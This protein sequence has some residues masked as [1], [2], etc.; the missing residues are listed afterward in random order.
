ME[1]EA[2]LFIWYLPLLS[3]SLS[4][5]SFFFGL[6]KFLCAVKGDK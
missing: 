3:L 5:C 2:S 6:S 1:E 4:L